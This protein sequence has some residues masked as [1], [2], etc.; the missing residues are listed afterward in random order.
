M[1]WVDDMDSVDLMDGS[2]DRGY[3][4]ARDKGAAKITGGSRVVVGTKLGRIIR[5]WRTFLREIRLIHEILNFGR[6]QPA[7]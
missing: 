3:W 7:I 1:D 6:C 2:A 5:V 4:R